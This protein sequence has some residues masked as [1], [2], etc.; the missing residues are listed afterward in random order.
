MMLAGCT[1][2]ALK[3]VRLILNPG[4][5]AGGMFNIGLIT[6]WMYTRRM[7]LGFQCNQ[8]PRKLHVV[9]VDIP[10]TARILSDGFLGRVQHLRDPS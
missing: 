8:E 10:T 1:S 6:Q 4:F 3:F 7:P 5:L 2:S 9:E